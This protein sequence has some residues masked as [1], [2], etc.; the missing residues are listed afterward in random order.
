MEWYR[1]RSLRAAEMF[2]DELEWAI[3]S[4]AK[5]SRQHSLYE[6]GTRRIVLRRFPYLVVFRETATGIE[7]V[8]VAHGHRRPEYLRDRMNDAGRLR[9]DPL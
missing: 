9:S 6:S 8:A 1:Q 4:I 2:L 5:H 7:I 3:E